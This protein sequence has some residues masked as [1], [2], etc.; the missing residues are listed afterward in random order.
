MKKSGAIS[1][2]ENRTKLFL[3]TSSC[4]GN[5]MMTLP[6]ELCTARASGEVSLVL[7]VQKHGAG[8]V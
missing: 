5:A 8:D 6:S 4:C 3:E 1:I 7:T 2:E